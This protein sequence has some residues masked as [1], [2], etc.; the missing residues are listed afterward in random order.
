M[1]DDF[2]IC[3]P[4]LAAPSAALSKLLPG[5]ASLFILFSTVSLTKSM[6]ARLCVSKWVSCGGE[7]KVTLKFLKFLKD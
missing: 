5:W 7:A 3:I 2:R 1:N 6:V 4:W